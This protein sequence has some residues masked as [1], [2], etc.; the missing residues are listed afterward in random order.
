MIIPP[1]RTA[2]PG[3]ALAAWLWI[4]LALAPAGGANQ[5][6]GLMG[7]VGDKLTNGSIVFTVVKVYRG[8]KYQKQFDTGEVTPA[9]A[10]EDVVAITCRIKNATPKTVSTF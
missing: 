9:N 4:G 8:D 3:P 6:G 2:K 10:N 5:I 7:K 1:T